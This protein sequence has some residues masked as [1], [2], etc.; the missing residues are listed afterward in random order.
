MLSEIVENPV[1]EWGDEPLFDDEDEEG[2][3]ADENDPRGAMDLP[4]GNVSSRPT[5]TKSIGS[6]LRSDGRRPRLPQQRPALYSFG[7]VGVRRDPI[8][9]QIIENRRTSIVENPYTRLAQ[10]TSLAARISE[11]V[12]PFEIRVPP[13]EGEEEEVQERIIVSQSERRAPVPIASELDDQGWDDGLLGE[14][15]RGTDECE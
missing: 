14:P 13:A 12:N 15:E 6:S 5:T 4:G 7:S 3:T 9:D 2:I 8:V 10:S 11:R 1:T